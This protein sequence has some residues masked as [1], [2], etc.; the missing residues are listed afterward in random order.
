MMRGGR[1]L[2]HAGPGSAQD[3]DLI[4]AGSSSPRPSF[5]RGPPASRRALGANQAVAFESDGG[6]HGFLLP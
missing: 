2:A 6:L 5:G 3:L 1:F 4:P